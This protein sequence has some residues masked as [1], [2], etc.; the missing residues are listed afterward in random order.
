MQSNKSITIQAQLGQETI[1]TQANSQMYN[2]QTLGKKRR[3]Q[4]FING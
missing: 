1:A 4:L 2:F 3:R